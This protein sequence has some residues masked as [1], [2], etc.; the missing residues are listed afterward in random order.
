MLMYL[1]HAPRS[2]MHMDIVEMEGQNPA[3][4]GRFS[5]FG[6]KQETHQSSVDSGAPD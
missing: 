2:G 5:D 4:V 1:A 6:C 3:K